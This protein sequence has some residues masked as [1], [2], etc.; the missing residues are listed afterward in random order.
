[1][2]ERLDP[3]SLL[4]LYARDLPRPVD[5][6]NLLTI[7]PGGLEWYRW[8][9]LLVAPLVY[10]GGGSVPWGGRLVA[11][12]HGPCVANRLLIARY[13][14]HR[15]WLAM[16]SNPYYFA[17]NSLRERGVSRFEASFTEPIAHA[18]LRGRGLVLVVHWNAPDDASL[19]R[20]CEAFAE[21]GGE[22]VY[23]SREAAPIDLFREKVATDPH[24][25]R[26]KRVAFFAFTTLSAIDAAR[27]GGVIARVEHA[28]DECAVQVF[29]REPMRAHFPRALM[30]RRGRRANTEPHA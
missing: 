21:S 14:S 6:L 24:P 3:R 26:F 29:R 16:V 19:A 18:R 7:E 25:L 20:V 28:T 30:L 9:G 5:V 17:I 12:L 27:A 2:L 4:R 22:L 13:R 23:A 15:R 8:Y 10:G 11:Q 1:M